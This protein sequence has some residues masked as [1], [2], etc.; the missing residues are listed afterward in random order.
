VE[1]FW[2]G[3]AKLTDT[4]RDVLECSKDWVKLHKMDR[5][6]GGVRL[7]GNRVPWRWNDA[8]RELQAE[9]EEEEVME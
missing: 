6:L 1:T 3:R 7:H 8:A 9:E 2:K 4:G 5:W